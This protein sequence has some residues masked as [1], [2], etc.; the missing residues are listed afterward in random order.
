MKTKTL[1]CLLGLTAVGTKIY[2]NYDDE[3]RYRVHG[4]TRANRVARA[5]M[6]IIYQYRIVKKLNKS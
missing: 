5:G 2:S 3:F 4:L 1:F 6:K